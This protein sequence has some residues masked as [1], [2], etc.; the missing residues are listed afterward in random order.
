MA[1]SKIIRGRYFREHPLCIKAG[2]L[3]ELIDHSNDG[4]NGKR[5]YFDGYDT[6]GKRKVTDHFDL[7][8]V[9]KE[10]AKSGQMNPSRSCFVDP[11]GFTCGA[12]DLKIIAEPES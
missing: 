9:F 4:T 1:K 6:F 10:V 5:L 2:T 8:P 3:V 7:Y 11:F 12:Y